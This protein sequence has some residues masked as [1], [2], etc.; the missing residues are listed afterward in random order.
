MQFSHL[1]WTFA[2]GF[3][4]D[5]L[6]LP[7]LALTKSL[8]SRG[9]LQTIGV[10]SIRLAQNFSLP[11][12]LS[13]FNSTS[14]T[15]D[16]ITCYPSDDEWPPIS[17]ATCRPLIQMIARGLTFRETRTWP[18]SA[19]P[20]Q[21]MYSGCDIRLWSGR[22]ESSFSLYDML[23]VVERIFA[24]CTLDQEPGYSGCGGDGPVGRDGFRVQVTS[25][26]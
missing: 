19:G 9:P 26:D 11:A 8:S 24:T 17:H 1:V 15:P 3:V 18:Y 4:S 5:T 13:L 23:V 21:W 6:A 12:T 7:S 20:L 22:T 10:S 2:L 16:P 14:R 25:G